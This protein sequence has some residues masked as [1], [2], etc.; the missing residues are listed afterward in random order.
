MNGLGKAGLLDVGRRAV[1]R[2][3]FACAIALLVS[4]AA[5]G[6]TRYEHGAV[7]QP[8][9]SITWDGSEIPPYDSG[10]ACKALLHDTGAQDGPGIYGRQYNAYYNDC[11]A[12]EQIAYEYLKIYWQQVPQ[13]RRAACIR[14]VARPD[15][16]R[17]NFPTM[18]YQYLLQ[19]IGLAAEQYTR[20]KFQP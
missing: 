15:G 13:A 5:H 14:Q 20:P 10:A 1:R 2:G 3:G 11:L 19:C 6:Q 12:P 9:G 8:D 18:Y 16:R 7:V 17:P 4:V